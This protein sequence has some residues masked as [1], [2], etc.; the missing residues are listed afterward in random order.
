M[1]Y[2]K[3]DLSVRFYS[4]VDKSGP[5]PA[6]C[7]DLGPC[8]LWLAQIVKSGYGHIR[9]GKP[10]RAHRVSWEIHRGSI[11]E[12]MSV[13]HHCDNRACVNPNHLHIGTALDNQADRKRHGV[14]RHGEHCHRSKL[15]NDLVKAIRAEYVPRPRGKPRQS[16]HGSHISGSPAFLAQKY[17]V[18]NGTVRHV[19]SM[20][21]WTEV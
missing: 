3:T 17:G 11:P 6:H 4:K 20:T 9:D 13:L 8:W 12:G 2:P 1:A 19:I 15:T 7:S 10:K 16:K 18:P 5:I 14:P 21:T